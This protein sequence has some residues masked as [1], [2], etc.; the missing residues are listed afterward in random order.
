[1]EAMKMEHEIVADIDGTVEEIVGAGAQVAADQV[2][3]RIAA[4]A[5]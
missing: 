3:A 4:A 2:L 1:M 5:G